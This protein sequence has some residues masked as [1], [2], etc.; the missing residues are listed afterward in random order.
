MVLRPTHVAGGVEMDFVDDLFLPPR[1]I[2][3]MGKRSINKKFQIKDILQNCL[4][5]ASFGHV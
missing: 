3:P 1:P 4:E 2:M 5:H